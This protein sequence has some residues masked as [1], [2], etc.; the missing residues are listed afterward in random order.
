VIFPSR[1][2]VPGRIDALIEMDEPI[3][4][5]YLEDDNAD[6]QLVRATLAAEGM[7]FRMVQV[8]SRSD[9]EAALESGSWKLILAD[10][11]LPG[12]SGVE[13]IEAVRRKCPAIPLL[14]ISGTIQEESVRDAIDRGAVGCVFKDRLSRLGSAVKEAL[15]EPPPGPEVR[16]AEPEI[17]SLL[18][19]RYRCLLEFSPE[20]VFLMTL[21][22]KLL[23]WN[24][25]AEKLT[26]WS[27]GEVVNRDLRSLFT[28]SQGSVW[29]NGLKT[30][31]ENGEWTGEIGVLAKSGQEL[32]IQSRWI[33]VRDAFGRVESLLAINTDLHEKRK[34]EAQYLRAQRLE[35]IGA[36]AGG[37]AHDLNNVLAPIL[38]SLHILKEH[39]LGDEGNNLL[40]T[41][42]ASAQRGA[43][44]VKQML[45]FARGSST[46]RGPV[47]L[48]HL[49]QE[50]AKIA[51]ETFPKNIQTQVLVPATLDAVRGDPTQLHQVLMNLCVNARD[52]MPQG[53]TLRVSAENVVIDDC[54]AHTSPWAKTG[55][56]VLITVSDTGIGVPPELLRRIFEPFFT[57]KGP[58]KGTGLGLSTVLG[59]VKDHNGFIEVQSQVGV[60]SRFQV[61]LPRAGAPAVIAPQVA[62]RDIPPG[63]GE[64]ILVV[65][66]EESIRQV[67]RSALERFNYRILLA[68][69]GTEAVVLFA[70]H[71]HAIQCVITDIAMPYMDGE[72]TIRALRRINPNIRFI[73]AS[74]RG[75]RLDAVTAAHLDIDAVLPKPF[76]TENLL[77]TLHRVLTN[78]S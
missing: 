55:P 28:L 72:T 11:K 49:I 30:A 66:D 61:Y 3:D 16:P 78:G 40:G 5:L 32:L 67:I 65:D 52:A 19:A 46:N 31:L 47:Q 2:Q 12:Y 17:L 1:I 24:P 13:A 69:D 57:T 73:I 9:F 29:E 8:A 53:G 59:I 42:E 22:F 50:M 76:T 75:A 45:S 77:Q 23:D 63:Q 74:G 58:D 7:E 4:I 60:G 14:L 33:V 21:G 54:F 43:E 70:Q 62:A 71:A 64:L 27:R 44:I 41:L 37:I 38:M 48:R 34:L 10:N 35:C 51:R 18:R 25:A 36:L 20:P 68:R 26:G 39:C 56:H 15:Q 6:F